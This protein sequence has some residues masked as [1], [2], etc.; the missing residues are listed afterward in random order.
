MNDD[1]SKSGGAGCQPENDEKCNRNF[2]S[3]VISAVGY[4]CTPAAAFAEWPTQGDSMPDILAS[5]PA[6]GWRYSMQQI[7]AVTRQL[8]RWQ[9]FKE[10]PTASYF[11]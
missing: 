7:N 2:S 4:N 3:A 6:G 5:M 9:A 11:Y 1:G 10:A 8:P